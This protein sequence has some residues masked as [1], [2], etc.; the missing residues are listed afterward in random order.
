MIWLDLGQELLQLRLSGLELLR[1]RIAGSR[2][3]CGD[4]RRHGVGRLK[5]GQ[6]TLEQQPSLPNAL[7]RLGEGL[8]LHLCALEHLQIGRSLRWQL[9]AVPLPVSSSLF[10]CSISMALASCSCESR[11]SLVSF[12]KVSR[13]RRFSSI[14]SEARRAATFWAV[15]ASGLR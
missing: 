1:R 12:A 15:C 5:V 7:R 2:C 4:G 11:N 10:S 3:R 6:L 13:S 14:K 8:D 9:A